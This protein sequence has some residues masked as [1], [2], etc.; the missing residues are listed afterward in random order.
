MAAQARDRTRADLI[1]D[2]LEARRDELISTGVAEIRSRMETYRRADPALIEDVSGHIA[3]HHDLLC[4]VLRRG[5]PA[6]AREFE[7]VARHA[8]LRARRGI[9]LSDF[10]EAFRTY[11]N[12]V[13]DAVLAASRSGG[14]SEEQALAAAR[15][16]I[17]HI[18]LATT[19]AS[20]A[21][22]EAQ[23]L[24]VADGDRARRDLLE[25]LLA[26][27]P[28][29][30]AA[31]L[32]AARVAGLEG[33]ARCLLIAA[34]PTV[35]PEEE[36][37]LRPAAITL[38]AAVDRGRAPLAVARHGEI[39][40]VKAL[41]AKERP[42]LR[43]ALEKACR[44]LTSRGTELAVGVSTAQDGV[45][46]LGNAYREASLALG[47]LG[48]HGGVMSLPD[49]SAFEYLMLR[50]DDVARRLIAP[51]IERFVAEDH[52][53]G[54]PLTRTLLAYAEAD[55]N[56]KAAAEALLIHVNTAHYRLARIAEKTGCDLRRL[57]DVID[58]MIAI[59]LYEGQPS[60]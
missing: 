41:N 5:R 16:V 56:A 33:D 25:D 59:R 2:A 11:H 50:G 4:A 42:S 44:R 21:Y 35:A 19:E 49:M 30:T 15:T 22:L 14:E 18:D 53:Q 24:L 20:T 55:L 39:V 38:A 7:F 47:R 13:W 36:A 29:A 58:L 40:V 52:E 6:T 31:G 1:A 46:T 8:A 54:G 12:V 10:L 28:P 9:S 37:V 48:P 23:Q 45:A 32:A 57:P 51:R 27:R 34:V 3:Q 17:R 26:G 43:V 60:R